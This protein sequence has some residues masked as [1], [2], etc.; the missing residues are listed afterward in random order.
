MRGQLDDV[1]K[2]TGR[3][4]TALSFGPGTSQRPLRLVPSPLDGVEC[5][6]DVVEQAGRAIST[7]VKTVDG[8]LDDVEKQT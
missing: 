2:Q 1:E 6:Q 3:I 8:H 4:S 7:G 5:R